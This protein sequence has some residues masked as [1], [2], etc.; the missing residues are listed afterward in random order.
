MG[1]DTGGNRKQGRAGAG[2]TPQ[3]AKGEPLKGPAATDVVHAYF[4]DK[5]ESPSM[6]ATTGDRKIEAEIDAGGE[7]LLMSTGITPEVTRASFTDNKIGLTGFAKS[8]GL[9]LTQIGVTQN[10]SGFTFGRFKLV[11]G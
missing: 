5:F 2:A 8:K 3:V 6:T 9:V 11:G 10:A 1:K 4:S 7:I